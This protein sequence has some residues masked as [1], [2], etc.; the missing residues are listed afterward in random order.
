MPTC[1]ICGGQTCEHD[2]HVRFRL[3][4]PVLSLPEQE[5]TEGTWMSDQAGGAN[6]SVMMRVPGVG[7]FLRALLPVSLSGGY[8]VTYGVWVGVRPE[9][10]KQAYDVWWD[11]SYVEFKV[12]GLL[13]NAIQPWGLLG[14]PVNLAVTDP[15]ATPVCVA[16]NDPA[17]EDVL[18]LEWPH[19]Q[20]LGPLP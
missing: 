6:Q 19:Q 15:D 9:D 14:T 1:Q 8:S 18:R 2:R 20:V 3:P 7:D 10:L 16:S 11:P 5:H 4:D 12:E 17:L 13:A